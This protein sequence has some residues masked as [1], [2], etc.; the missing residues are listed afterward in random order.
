[1]NLEKYRADFPV[2]NQEIEGKPIIYLDN[3]CMTLKPNC[4]VDA[5]NDYYTKFS[6]CGGRSV[7]KFA[8]RVTVGVE[9]ARAKLQKYI[10]ASSPNEIVFTR[11]TTEGI[12]LVANSFGL[13]KGDLVLTTD[14]EH[15]SN[16]APWHL[17]RT[18]IGIKHKVVMSNED[19]T[20]N[21]E[22]FSEA[23]DKNVK[24]VSMVQTSNLD[25]YTIP[26]KEVIKIA[27]DNNIPV[28]LDSAQSAPHQEVDVQKLDADFLAFSIHKMCGPT[29]V[30]VLYGKY[31]LLEELSPF[32]VGGDTVEK[33]TY[34]ESLF[35][36]PPSRFEAGL[37]NYA[38]FIG[39]GAAADYLSKI[40][41]ENI[42]KHEES[43][44]TYVCEE[45]ENMP[46]V[47]IIGPRDAKLRS[48]ITSFSVADM[49]PHD[50]AMILDEVANI[51]IRSGMHCVHSW[52]NAKQI[53]GS[54]RVA[55]YLYN[56][57]SEVDIFI[58]QLR[59][60]IKT[61]S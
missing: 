38:G 55:F 51:M 4:V 1:M 27:H 34:D 23:I 11:N 21:L 59:E 54:A 48:G 6:A 8:T 42:R 36:K 9:D 49:N 52:F 56:T 39:S 40:G 29:G 31:H 37:Q 50:I 33:T 45:M 2:L 10:N 19:S 12:N 58:E 28:M 46:E 41:L 18:K 22:N 47:T 15:N 57:K 16:L 14:R 53:E 5:M 7:H 35:L 44:N 17:L 3:A 43:L 26:A 30:G 20:F 13:K 24:L 61:F 32:V 60:I 25:G